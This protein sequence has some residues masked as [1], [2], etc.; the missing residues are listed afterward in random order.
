MPHKFGREKLLK[1]AFS[2]KALNIFLNFYSLFIMY[3]KE[4][5]YATKYY[6]EH[7]VG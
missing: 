6:T 7:K 3:L 4:M 2:T 5:C 1:P